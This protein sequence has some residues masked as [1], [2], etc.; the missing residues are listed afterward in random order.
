[1]SEDET[2]QMRQRALDIQRIAVETRSEAVSEEG[3]VRV[4]AGPGGS[5]K[6]LDLRLNAFEL[7]GVELGELIVKTL[8]AAD[9]KVAAELS[10]AIERKMGGLDTLLGEG[11]AR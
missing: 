5:V 11:E 7:S 2:S 3:E 6:E 8:R 1:M 4:V 9:E 10:A